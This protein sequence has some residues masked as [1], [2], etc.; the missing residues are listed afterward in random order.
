M[1][2]CIKCGR[3]STFALCDEC[4]KHDCNEYESYMRVVCINTLF[5]PTRNP[6]SKLKSNICASRLVRTFI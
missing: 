3:P 5:A 4:F 6:K 1:N 2:I